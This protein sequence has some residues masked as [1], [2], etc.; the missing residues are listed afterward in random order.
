MNT[1]TTIF[2]LILAGLLLGGIALY[3][4]KL[5]RSW[6]AANRDSHLLV[7]DRSR[8]EGIDIVSN[9]DKVEL[10]RRGSQWVMD[11]PVKDR[12]SLAAINEILACCETL[13]KE[14][15]DGCRN[16]DKKQQ[17]AF[18]VFKPA[19]HLKLIGPDMPAEVLLGNDTAVEG[20]LYARLEGSDTIFVI[21]NELR[22]LIIRKPDEFRDPQLADFEA[23]AVGKVTVKTA[24]GEIDVARDS[25]GWNVLK[26]LRARADEARVSA[27]L[28][29][30]LHTRIGAFLP[31]NS[32]NLNSYG[33]SEPR[34]TVTF[35]SVGRSQPAVLEIG[36]RDEKTGGVYGRFSLRGGVCLLPKES[37]NILKLQPNDLRERRLLRLDLDLVDRITLRPA[38]KPAVFL[39]RAREE[40]TVSGEGQRIL[41]ANPAASKVKV[42]QFVNDLQ[43]RQIAG[44]VTDVASDLAKYGFDQPQL[45]IVFSSYASENTAESDAGERPIFTLAFGKTE[46]NLV[47]ARLENEPFIVSV[48]QALLDSINTNWADWR[49]PLLFRCRSQEIL[50]FEITPYVDGAARQPVSYHLEANNW[51]ISDRIPGTV[52][53]GNIQKFVNALSSITA[54]H[55]TNEPGPLVPSMIIE[56][57]ATGN[58]TNR[59]T[60]GM[61]EE[62]GSCRAAFQGKPGIFRLAATDVAALRLRLID[63]IMP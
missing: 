47:Y 41:P 6:Q 32:A 37:E 61:I 16:S 33:L 28:N 9:E 35:R 13:T 38:G 39:R 54:A 36:A 51:L 19:L 58:R 50:S 23:A 3:E 34:G 7:F 56:F 12:A 5:P 60:L 8:V 14:P 2:L 43:T 24:A 52:N 49:Q 48:D 55:W 21:G 53:R 57:T 17:K 63:P 15:V 26:P 44:F 4:T 62:D 40:W 31:E 45:R 20:K 42:L 59:I 30:V 18:G 27:F 11:S 46:G 10:R 22:N 1:K 29:S 25:N